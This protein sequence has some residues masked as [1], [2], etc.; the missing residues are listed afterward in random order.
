MSKKLTV[1][2]IR[3]AFAATAGKFKSLFALGNRANIKITL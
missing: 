2:E 3:Q 1:T